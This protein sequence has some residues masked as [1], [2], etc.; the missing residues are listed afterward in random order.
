MSK[1]IFIFILIINI[2]RSSVS[3]INS[4]ETYTIREKYDKIVDLIINSNTTSSAYFR[5]K[6]KNCL[7]DHLKLKNTETEINKKFWTFDIEAILEGAAATCNEDTVKDSL[8]NV[9]MMIE[10][11]GERYL[12]PDVNCYKNEFYKLE[13]TATILNGFTPNQEFENSE[14]CKRSAGTL[15]FAIE[16]A[17]EELRKSSEYPQ[18]LSS[19]NSFNLKIIKLKI[20]ILK[21]DDI[22]DQNLNAEA[23]KIAEY[24]K[25]GTIS[26]FNCI[27]D[28]VSKSS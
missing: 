19:A 23:L 7:E 3:P 6:D 12:D 2:L 24:F 1:I 8:G 28:E 13:P 9:M 10:P 5:I 17:T 4:Q 14:N 22:D 16:H 11:F 15:I 25:F 21:G 20:Q 27:M 18:C 26:T